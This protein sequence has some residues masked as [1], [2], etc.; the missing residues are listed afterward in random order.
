[1]TTPEGALSDRRREELVAAATRVVNEAAGLGEEDGLRVWVLMHEVPEGR[2]GAGGQI[3]RFQQ[4]LE[5]A[6]GEREK[7]GAGG[8]DPGAWRADRTRSRRWPGWGRPGPPRWPGGRIRR[9]P[10]AGKGVQSFSPITP[11]T[12][13]TP[14][15]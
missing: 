13:D 9:E 3:I 5:L 8:L 4:L 7:A 14:R 12:L 6:R 1:M 2:W 11:K 15:P 10:A